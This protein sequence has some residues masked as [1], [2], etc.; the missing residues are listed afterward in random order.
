MRPAVP[1]NVLRNGGLGHQRQVWR[2]FGHDHHIGATGATATFAEPAG[3]QHV[4]VVE[5]PR[6]F[7]EQHVE[8]GPHGA[9]L[10]SIVEHHHRCVRVLL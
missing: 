5:R 4:V 8:G 1:A 7:R 3:G 6:P 2:A 10:E 9:V